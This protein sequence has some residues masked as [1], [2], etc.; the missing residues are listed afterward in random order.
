MAHFANNDGMKPKDYLM[1]K[2]HL[3]LMM[4]T[5]LSK[6]HKNQDGMK[7]QNLQR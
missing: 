7:M 6:S 3:Q 1:N 2:D 5:T 4:K